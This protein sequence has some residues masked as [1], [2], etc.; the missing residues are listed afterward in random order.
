M[1][2]SSVSHDIELYNDPN[3][4]TQ[5][6]NKQLSW[7][8]THCLFVYFDFKLNNYVSLG[9]DVG[10]YGSDCKTCQGCQQC[11]IESGLCGMCIFIK[12]RQLIKVGQIS[13]F[14]F[15]LINCNDTWL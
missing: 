8:E 10:Q 12:L 14:Y 13:I 11:D 6:L 15:K 2:R 4:R 3:L 7:E 9:C 5:T 1:F